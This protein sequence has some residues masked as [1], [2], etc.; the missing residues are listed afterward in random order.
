MPAPSFEIIGLDQINNNPIYY[1]N[2]G[3]CGVVNVKLKILPGANYPLTI[4]NLTWLDA[5]SSYNPIQVNGE[6]WANPLTTPVVVNPGDEIPVQLAVC[7]CNGPGNIFVGQ[8]DITYDDPIVGVGQTQQSLFNFLETNMAMLPPFTDTYVNHYPCD[9]DPDCP[10]RPGFLY[11]TNP[12]VSDVW[13]GVITGA[14]PKCRVDGVDV[15]TYPAPGMGLSFLA[16]AGQTYE[17]ENY[18]CPEVGNVSWCVDFEICSE[19]WSS[20]YGCLLIIDTPVTCGPCG[21]SCVEMEL[22]EGDGLFGSTQPCDS[23]GSV[24][25]QYSIGSKLKSRWVI[26]YDNNFFG[27][28]IDFYFNPWLFGDFCN[29]AA[30]YP[31]GIIDAPPPAAWHFRIQPIHVASGIAYPMT[32]IGAGP[33]GPSQKNWSATIQVLTDM[34]VQIIFTFY[35]IEDLDNWVDAGVVP[36]QPK[37][38]KNH[39]SAPADLTNTTLSVYNSDK[40]IC[41]LAYV[42]DP[43]I[44]IEQSPGVTVP[45][46]C[47]L[48]SSIPFTARFYNSGLYGGASEMTNPVFEFERNGT[49]VPGLASYAKTKVTFRW[50][51]IYTIAKCV[52]WVIDAQDFNDTVD[53]INNYDGSVAEITTNPAIAVINNKLQSPSVG[54]TFLGGTTYECSAYVAGG[55]SGSGQYYIIAIPM[56]P[57]GLGPPGFSNSFITGPVPVTAVPGIEGCCEPQVNDN[58]WVD[59]FNLYNASCFTPTMKER[60]SNS[61]TFEPGDFGT[62]LE[63]WGWDP[64]DF[65]WQEFIKKVTLNVYRRVQNYPTP[66]Q[67]TYFV[68]ESYQSIRDTAVAGNW[69]NTDPSKFLVSEVSTKLDL[70][71]WGRVRYESAVPVPNTNV[72]V[73]NV[74]TPMNRV[75]AGGAA[76]TYVSVNNA[77]FDWGNTDI[78]FEYVIQ[79][80]LAFLFGGNPCFINHVFIN[81]IKPIDFETTPN[82]YGQL[83]KPLLIEGVKGVTKTEITGQFCAKDFD[84]LLVTMESLA[85]MDGNVYAFLDPYPYGVNGLIESDP[86]LSS[87]VFVQLTDPLIYSQDPTHVGIKSEWRLDVANLPVGKYQICTLFLDKKP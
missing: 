38:L 11:F 77:N 76:A 9:D 39:I 87:T 5:C 16:K 34:T 14:G 33:N 51:S 19:T 62:C 7:A 12:T 79:Y 25:N 18:Q 43:K 21:L 22:T 10:P 73:A 17:I 74:A 75:P 40:S 80:D 2:A 86:T 3:C 68:F 65:G 66:L 48:V 8:M 27:G 64:M 84:Y 36:N 53:F 32:L 82:P 24:V 60:I 83:F 26:Q 6:I 31:G 23:S 20:T 50:D 45:F 61:I 44:Q 41:L 55:I 67:N 46:E 59:Y 47:E 42:V 30:K 52:F 78:F 37:L 58:Y 69:I 54:P 4:T 72:F 81:K 71:W 85:P 13:V 15:L 56:V 28:N 57:D 70:N 63:N 49:I 29:F 1:G 35:L